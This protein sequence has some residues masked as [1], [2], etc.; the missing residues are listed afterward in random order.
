MSIF[1]A[2]K[3]LFRKSSSSDGQPWA[4]VRASGVQDQAV[5]TPV[6][7]TVNQAQSA[8]SSTSGLSA[9]FDVNTIE[10]GQNIILSGQVWGEGNVIRIEGT[11]NPQR[12]HLSVHGNNNRIVIGK[13]SLMNNLAVEIGSQRW[14]SSR[15]SLSIGEYFSIASGG[16]FI[17]PN[18]GNV[19]EI[20]D[21]C[22]FSKSVQLRGGEFP[23]MI[24]DKATGA[25]LD[26]SGGIFIGDHAWI[27]EG[28]FIGKAVTIP[29]ECIVGARSVVTKRFSEENVVIAGN[30][31]RIVKRGVQWVSTEYAIDAEYPELSASFHASRTN[32]INLAEK[33]TTSQPAP[34][35][36]DA[37]KTGVDTILADEQQ[38]S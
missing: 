26:E 37:E 24:F 33:H 13:R 34:A 1:N 27:G 2:L 28:V 5:A 31:A 10:I 6:S 8:S 18:S 25:Y 9:H 12:I 16:R 14:P 23:H 21:H 35:D 4:N 19:V 11:R 30:P 7:G 15:T 3:E 32:Q 29:R 38:K 20:G 36:D 22:M 17:L